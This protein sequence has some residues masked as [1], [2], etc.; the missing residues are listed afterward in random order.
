M[1]LP[2]NAYLVLL[3]TGLFA[4][5]SCDSPVDSGTTVSQTY[6]HGRA[7][8]SPDG[9]TIA[10]SSLVSGQEGIYVT[11]TLG[12]NIKQILPGEGVG[13]NWSPNGNW[14]VFAKTGGIFKMKPNGDSLKQLTAAVGGVRPAWSND[15]SKIAFIK[16]DAAGYS[17]LWVYDIAKDTSSLVISRGD[18]PSWLSTTGEIIVLDGTYNSFSGY[19]AYAFLAI[20]PATA[21]SRII[22]S[23][24]AVGSVGF[25]PVSPKGTDIVFGFLPYN[26][27]SEIYKYSPASN[28]NAMLTSD[29]GDYPAWSP[30]GSRIVY[31]RTQQG[32][33]GLW[34]MNVDG[35]GK[36]RLTKP[37]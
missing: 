37:Q 2:K 27:I 3:M 30:D 24:S 28:T 33:G 1:K 7:A 11:D 18:F 17:S 29:G 14:I 4:L 25:C 21:A 12:A 34:I 20:N 26:D 31:T 35:S 19:T 15:G 8:W 32:D 6:L 23:F 13:V 5:S 10:F 36:R 9:K 22:A 16:I